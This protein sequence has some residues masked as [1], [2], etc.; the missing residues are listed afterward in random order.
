VDSM[1]ARI[2][3]AAQQAGI[4]ILPDPT[5]ARALY[6]VELDQEIPAEHWDAVAKIIAYVMKLRGTR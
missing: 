3:E 4:P 1:A 5:L 6:R 2:R